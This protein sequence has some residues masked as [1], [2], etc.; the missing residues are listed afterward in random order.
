M[1]SDLEYR[2]LIFTFIKSR[3]GR[4][5]LKRNAD[6]VRLLYR[7]YTQHIKTHTRARARGARIAIDRRSYQARPGCIQWNPRNSCL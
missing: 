7:V 6:T 4:R 1:S 5:H 3:D 2:F